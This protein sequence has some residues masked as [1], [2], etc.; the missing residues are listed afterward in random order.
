MATQDASVDDLLDRIRRLVADRQELRTRGAAPELL[1][2]NRR[3]IA[4]AQWRLSDALIQQ[5]RPR[6]AA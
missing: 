6:R 5:Y 2:Q 4:E 3:L 1:E